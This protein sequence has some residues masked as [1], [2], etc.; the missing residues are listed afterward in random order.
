MAAE[1][2]YLA[3]TKFA[4][5]LERADAFC[6]RFGLRV[7]VLLAP[8]AGA[9]PP[10][11]SAAVANAGG[12]GACGA[13][14][15]QP[16]AIH[17]WASELRARTPGPFQINLWVPDPAPHRDAASEAA[18]LAFLA[19]WGPAVGPDAGDA[20]PP[21]FAGQCE[22]LFDIAPPIVSSVMGLYPP[23]VVDRLKARGISWWAN[24]STVAEARA[25]ELA[26]AE[27]IVAQG[28]EA[29]GHRGCFDASRAEA[30]MVGLF[31]LIPAIV[32]AVRVPVVATG[33]IADGRGAAAALLLGASA[34]Q[35]GTGF[36]RS[37]EAAIP[38]AWAD[39]LATTA[40]EGTMI[41][42]AFSGRAGRCVETDYALAAASPGV[43]KPAP[44]P[45]QRGLTKAMR[46]AAVTCNDL[47]RMQA[48]AGQSCMLARAEPAADIVETIGAQLVA[49]LS[50]GPEGFPRME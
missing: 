46:E 17:A 1:T 9:C 31:S 44:Y 20:T 42:R 25:A 14:L 6:Q 49:L 36:L 7:P 23:D 35:I 43:P 22:A 45:V 38:P 32:D 13:V 4:P 11:L 29:G 18:L 10:A 26:G 8:M 34:V 3:L 47:H 16:P 21:D 39:A 48:W 12:L 19:C 5:P 40:P 28:M 15:M 24:V 37:P 27:V 2:W 33:G 30:T 50:A 41:S